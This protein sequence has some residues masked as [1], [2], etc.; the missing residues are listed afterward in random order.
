MNIL[1]LFPS[2]VF[3]LDVEER[4]DELNPENFKYYD[5]DKGTGSYQSFNLRVLNKYPRINK[6]LLKKFEKVAKEYLNF[7]HQFI[8]TTSWFTKVEKDGYSH[9]HRHKNSFYS[10]IYYFD[11]YTNESGELELANPLNDKSDFLLNSEDWNI[12]NSDGWTIPPQKNL[13]VFFPSYVRHSVKRNI[14]SN[15]RYSLAFN[16]IPTG[17][18]GSGDSAIDTSWLTG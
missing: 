18:Y 4:T 7:N 1:P 16:I 15:I 8:I 5:T 2:T 3:T 17:I 10:G 11:E 6:L 14:G 12:Y 13:L 9:V